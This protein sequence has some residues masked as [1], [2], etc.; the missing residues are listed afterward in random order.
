MFKMFTGAYYEPI[1]AFTRAISAARKQKYILGL[2][3][4]SLTASMQPRV[5]VDWLNSN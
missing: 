3:M 2:N 4:L 1:S 5:C